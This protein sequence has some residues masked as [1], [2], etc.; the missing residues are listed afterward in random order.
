MEYTAVKKGLLDFDLVKIKCYILD[1]NLHVLDLNETVSTIANATGYNKQIYF[2]SKQGAV[3]VIAGEDFIKCCKAY[4]KSQP[5]A[6]RPYNVAEMF[7]NLAKYVSIDV[8]IWQ[9][10][11]PDSERFNGDFDSA[12]SSMLK[13][14]VKGK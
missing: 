9:A 14:P 12:V 3:H 5:K 4:L 13:Q 11:L 1:N 10:C 2:Q 6:T 7:I 8:F